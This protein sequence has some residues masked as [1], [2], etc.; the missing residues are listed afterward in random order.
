[1]FSLKNLLLF[2]RNINYPAPIGVVGNHEAGCLDV[3]KDARIERV[4]FGSRI[5]SDE[6]RHF[7]R[8]AHDAVLSRLVQ[9]AGFGIV[10]A[11][12]HEMH[13]VVLAAEKSDEK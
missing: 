10:F 11:D 12:F 4:F 2:V 6:V 8:E 5:A 7:L 9:V 3:M 1:M 13:V